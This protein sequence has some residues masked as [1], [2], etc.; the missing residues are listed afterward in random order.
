MATKVEPGYRVILFDDWG[1]PMLT[2]A[3]ATAGPRL[4][5]R[6][7]MAPPAGTRDMPA[8]GERRTFVA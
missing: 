8:A 2:I 6:H 4:P 7:V 1:K 5:G 3:A